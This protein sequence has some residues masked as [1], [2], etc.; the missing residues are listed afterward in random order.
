IA[1]C[2]TKLECSNK[3]LLIRQRVRAL[4]EERPP[5]PVT[6]VIGPNVE[7]IVRLISS[8]CYTT[9]VPQG[10]DTH[11]PRSMFLRLLASVVSDLPIGDD[12]SSLIN[13]FMTHN[14]HYPKDS[15]CNGEWIANVASGQQ[16][17]EWFNTHFV[18]C[19]RLC[20]T[21]SLVLTT[22]AWNVLMLLVY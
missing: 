20:L 21:T 10:P 8:S 14:R 19:V 22:A 16:K 13:S 15:L 17:P 1:G 9:V 7:D 3:T 5:A 4:N 11:S 18:H 12:K 2:S 6:C